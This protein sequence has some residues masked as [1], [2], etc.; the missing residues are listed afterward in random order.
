M[1][2]APYFRLRNAEEKDI[3][4]SNFKD[5]YLLIQFWASWD[6]VSRANNAMFRRIY[7]KEQKNKN[8]AL[9]GV[10]LDLNKKKWQ[11]TIKADT[12][13]W[14]QVC[15]FSGWSGEIIKQFAIQTLPTNILLSPTGRIE[16]K[17]LDEKA[18]ENKLKEI[19]E[20]EKEKSLTTNH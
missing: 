4:R 18:I 15:D 14:E 20:K 10:S 12:L 2:S 16:G 13:K 1:K 6:T 9:L 3:S 7:K 5:Q 19:A 8:F 17:N 11:E